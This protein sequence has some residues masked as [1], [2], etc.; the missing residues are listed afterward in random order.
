MYQSIPNKV[1]RVEVSSIFFKLPILH[2][3]L[4]PL[5]NSIYVNYGF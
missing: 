2:I 1:Y 5:D 4:Q 3:Q